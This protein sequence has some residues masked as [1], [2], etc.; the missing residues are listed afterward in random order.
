MIIVDT[1]EP[2]KII[3]LLKDLGLEVVRKQLEVADYLIRATSKEGIAHEIPIERKTIQDFA[4]SIIDGRLWKQTYMMSIEYP[5]SYMVIVGYINEVLMERLIHRH[6]LIGA[7]C[8]IS[9]K[10]APSGC[11]G[12]IIPIILETDYDFALFVYNLHKR[13]EEGDFD[14]LPLPKVR[15]KS[16]YK[17][18]LIAMYSCIPGVGEELAKHLAERFPNLELLLRATPTI[19]MTIPGIGKMKARK[20]YEFLHKK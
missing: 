11:R 1:R 7:L 8:S 12:V 16:N 5:I 15:K 4:Q 19:L 13:A 18:A 10:R 17:E 6:A 3:K 9:I 2:E 14:R 20:I